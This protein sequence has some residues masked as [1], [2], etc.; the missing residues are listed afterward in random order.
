MDRVL[1]LLAELSREL[2]GRIIRESLNGHA[3]QNGA[4]K[5]ECLHEAG[6]IMQDEILPEFHKGGLSDQGRLKFCRVMVLLHDA[7]ILDKEPSE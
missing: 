6:R 7:G 5:L 1:N 3:T 4:Y 2:Y